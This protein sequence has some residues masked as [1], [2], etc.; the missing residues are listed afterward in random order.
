MAGPGKT[1]TTTKSADTGRVLTT[2]TKGGSCE[3]HWSNGAKTVVT[4]GPSK[5]VCNVE[6]PQ[7]S[8]ENVAKSI[9]CQ[10]GD[11]VLVADGNVKIKAKNIIF[12]AE[13]VSPE[14][15]IEMI[16]NGLMNLQTNETLRV[17]GGEVQIVSEKDVVLDA[18]GFLNM[19]GDMKNAGSSTVASLVE[20][21]LG[22]G[23]ASTLSGI[24][25]SLR[26]I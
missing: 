22:G 4:A 23:W 26:G 5:E 18:T 7:V 21:Y 13:G 25:G 11:F 12:E 17:Q 9:Y 1:E 8:D 15:K 20:S 14:G 6:P 2:W 16:A 3:T 10:N 19:I 24:S